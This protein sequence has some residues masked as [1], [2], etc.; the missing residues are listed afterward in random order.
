MKRSIQLIGL[1]L[2]LAVFNVSAGDYKEN[3]NS[4]DVKVYY[5]HATARC[6][7]CKAVEAVTQKTLKDSYGDKVSFTSINREKEKDNPLIKKYKVSGQTLLVVKGDKVVNLTN[8]A[9]L[10]ARTKPEKL[11]SKIKSTIDKLLK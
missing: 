7:T 10:N 2:F 5:F 8:D 9:F 11:T 4:K 6:A 1:F 3:L